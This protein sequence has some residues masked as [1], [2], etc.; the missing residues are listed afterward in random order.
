MRGGID[1]EVAERNRWIQA[2]QKKIND[3]VMGKYREREREIHRLRDVTISN[4]RPWSFNLTPFTCSRRSVFV[5]LR[6]PSKALIN[7]RKLCKPVETSEKEAL[8]K[9]K[10]QDEEVAAKSSVCTSI[11]LVRTSFVKV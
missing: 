4:D 5:Y 2:E 11:E 6:P 9:K 7:K 1:E 8:D 10:E 3:S